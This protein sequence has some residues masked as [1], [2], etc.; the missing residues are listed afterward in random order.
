MEHKSEILVRRTAEAVGL[1]TAGRLA[2]DFKIGAA[3]RLIRPAPARSAPLLPGKVCTYAPHVGCRAMRVFGGGG[4]P[5]EG[6]REFAAK[7]VDLPPARKPR[8]NPRPSWKPFVFWKLPNYDE[9]YPHDFL[10]RI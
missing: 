1:G 9:R 10:Q 3:P 8:P 6:L 5:G 7:A 2:T 4:G